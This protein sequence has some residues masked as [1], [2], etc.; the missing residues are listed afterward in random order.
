[1]GLE[2]LLVLVLNLLILITPYRDAPHLQGGLPILA[3]GVKI[4]INIKL[5]SM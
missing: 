2:G 4:T 3:A 1:M 5:L